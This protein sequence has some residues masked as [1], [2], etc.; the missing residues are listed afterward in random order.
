MT[1]FE[2]IQKRYSCRAYQDKQIEK[3]ILAQLLEAARLAPRSSPKRIFVTGHSLGGALALTR[4]LSS[5]LYGVT[6][7]DP[8]TF[9]AV[10]LILIAVALLACYIPEC[11]F[12]NFSLLRRIRFKEFFKIRTP[13]QPT[14]GDIAIRTTQRF[15]NASR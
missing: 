7:T 6:P 3:E 12:W 11:D 1:V 4:F 2:T 13:T 9:I 5:L 14:A 10:S 8:L 15:G